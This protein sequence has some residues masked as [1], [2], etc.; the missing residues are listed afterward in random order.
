VKVAVFNSKKA[1]E[2]F[3]NDRRNGP[4]KGGFK[5]LSKRLKE[6]GQRPPPKD[7]M[8]IL[9]QTEKSKPKEHKKIASPAIR[10]SQLDV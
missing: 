10:R 4:K 8:E 6:L 3:V 5:N 2:R 1:K 7:L 9:N